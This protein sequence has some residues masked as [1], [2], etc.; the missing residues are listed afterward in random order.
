MKMM[1]RLRGSVLFGSEAKQREYESG[2]ISLVSKDK[3]EVEKML[4]YS[5]SKA[6]FPTLCAS[7]KVRDLAP[8]F[9]SLVEQHR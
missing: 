3:L 5:T 6:E 1:K 4:L 8:Y 2:V 9:S 7:V